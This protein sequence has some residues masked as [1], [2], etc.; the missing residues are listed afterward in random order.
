MLTSLNIVSAFL[1]SCSLSTYF[2][3]H[4]FLLPTSHLHAPYLSC[5]SP[6]LPP[7]LLPT[8]VITS[9]CSLHSTSFLPALTSII[10]HPWSLHQASFL[11]AFNLLPPCS[12]HLTSFPPA[13]T[14]GILPS[15][16]QPPSLLLP[17][18]GILPPCSLHP[19]SFP[20]APYIRH[21][22]SLLPT[23]DLLPSL[24]STSLLPLSVMPPPC[25]LILTPYP[26]FS[27]FLITLSTVINSARSMFRMLDS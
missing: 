19:T 25:S 11:P 16:I 22:S 15:C 6:Y 3:P 10:P 4:I 7:L 23:S 17:T 14:S 18:S 20:P 5:N 2:L 13:P 26:L 1:I 8:S 9:P 21:P 12:L 24:H 27:L